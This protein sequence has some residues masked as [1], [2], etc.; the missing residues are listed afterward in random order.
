MFKVSKQTIKTEIKF[1]QYFVLLSGCISN[2]E[3]KSSTF[4]DLVSTWSQGPHY[5]GI[6]LDALWCGSWLG[7]WTRS[8]TIKTGRPAGFD[9]QDLVHT[10]IHQNNVMRTQRHVLTKSRNNTSTNK[11]V[12]KLFVF[13]VTLT[14][15]LNI[16][17]LEY[18]QSLLQTL[19]VS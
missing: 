16:F 18:K 2:E 17:L 9:S 8:L 5:N 4:S 6:I 19:F 15:H 7:R 11:M 12:C 1:T 10:I 14:E 3:I 13:I